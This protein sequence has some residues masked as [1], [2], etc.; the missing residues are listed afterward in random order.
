M[1]NWSG[2]ATAEPGEDAG[3]LVVGNKTLPFDTLS[4]VDL[5]DFFKQTKTM[6]NQEIAI[7]ITLLQEGETHRRFIWQY[8]RK[9]PSQY[10]RYWKKLVF[11]GKG[12][13][14]MMFRTEKDLMAHVA[15]TRGAIGYI[16][17]TTKPAG[18]KIIKI[19]D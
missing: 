7:N 1:S 16:S 3:V 9:T 8:F 18:V 4:R 11:S 6:W 13:T 14:P 5:V 17:E 2:S 12:R 15:L 10:N 19:T